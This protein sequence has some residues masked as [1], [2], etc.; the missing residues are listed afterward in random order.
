MTATAL[1]KIKSRFSLLVIKVQSSMEKNK[2]KVTRLRQFLLNFFEGNCSIPDVTDLDKI[3]NTITEAKLWGYGNYG[4]LE[5]LAESFLPEDDPA[6]AQVTE[7]KSQLS[8]FYTT[9]SI[10]DFINLSEYGGPT[11]DEKLPFSPKKYSSYYHKLTV[12]LKLD[13]SVKLSEL[14]LDYVDKLWKALMQEF[15]LPPLTAV[16]DKIVE[17]SLKITWL[18]LSH[19]MEKIKAVYFKSITFFQRYSITRIEIDGFLLY[20]ELLV[21][22]TALSLCTITLATS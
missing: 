19:I 2:V 21:S 12:E 9:T 7:Y 22:M 3:F 4:P 18:I 8:G 14:T 15:H 10:I 1:R 11:E 13:R 17:G 5:E 20:D 16:M 6:R